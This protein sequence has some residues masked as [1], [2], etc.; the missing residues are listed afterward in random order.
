MILGI[1][2]AGQLAQMLALA[3]NPLGIEVLCLAQDPEVPA[4]PVAQLFQCAPNDAEALQYFAEA[5]DVVTYENENIDANILQLIEPI[6]PVYPSIKALRITQDR[7]LE[8][9]LFSKLNI[10]AAPTSNVTSEEEL[11][12]AVKEHGYPAILKTR[13]FGYDG[14]GQ[15]LLRNNKDITLAWAE[16]GGKESKLILEGFVKFNTEVSIIAVR[17]QNGVCKFYPLCENCHSEGILRY[18]TIPVAKKDLQKTA[19]KYAQQI[20]EHLD[21]VG[22]IAIEFFVTSKG[23]IANEIAPRVHNSGHWTI[24]GAYTSQFE[25]HIRALFNFPLGLTDLVAPCAMVNMISNLAKREEILDIQGAHYYTYGKHA[26]QNRK[27]GH[28]TIVPSNN[29]KLKKAIEL[30]SAHI[31][32]V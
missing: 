13:R 12:A 10:P 21:Y 5:V 23:L 9:Q 15:Y 29:D 14:K 6:T 31:R 2:G 19:E 28:V 17:D 20:M 24:E 27:L 16:L 11:N 7:L 8:K 1:I 32:S 26:R 25:N 22:T 4:A 30:C 3:A 18:T